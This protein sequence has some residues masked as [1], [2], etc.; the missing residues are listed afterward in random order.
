MVMVCLEGIFGGCETARPR[1]RAEQ[2][3]SFDD[4]LME[5]S[6]GVGN[7]AVLTDE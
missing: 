5:K 1:S 3:R 6:F 2:S 4:I 7:S